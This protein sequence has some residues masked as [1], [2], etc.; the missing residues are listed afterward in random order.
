[1][2][3]K[4]ILKTLKKEFRNYEKIAFAYLFGSFVKYPERAK[5]IDIAVFVKG[6]IPS[7]FERKLSLELSKKVRKD[8]EIFVLNDMPLILL[9][10]VFRTGILLFSRNEKERIDFESKKLTEVQEFNEIIEYYNLMR[11]KRYESG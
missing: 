3:H 6:K 1:M 5:D 7:K 9:S 2:R 10:E 4:E 11:C 8:V